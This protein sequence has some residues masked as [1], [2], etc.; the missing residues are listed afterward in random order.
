MDIY[1][2]ISGHYHN[3]N[4]DSSILYGLKALHIAQK[5]NNDIAI[6]DT[7]IALGIVSS[8]AGYFEKA[9]FFLE[10]AETLAIQRSNLRK[11]VHAIKLMGFVCA[12]WGKLNT[13][14]DYHL[15]C[16]K[17]LETEGWTNEPMYVSTLSNIGECYRI[18]GNTEMAIYYLKKAETKC[19]ELGYGSLLAQIFKEYASNYLRQNNLNDALQYTLKAD[20]IGLDAGVINICS[21]KS[22][23]ATIYLKQNNYAKALQYAKEAYEHAE[24]LKDVKLYAYAR[25]ILSDVYLAQKRYQEA[26]T[27]ALKVWNADSTNMD[28]SRA[29]AENLALA[30][31]Y[32]GNTEKAAY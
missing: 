25:K 14:I 5:L 3:F 26:E 4:P 2:Q 24:L 9:L 23:F 20:S 17:I 31:I 1:L 10:Q 18:L 22:L 21:I 7:Y 28:E 19:K 30:N 13:S 16:L 27:E 6:M 15:K 11:E 12:E 8:F 29:V 32:M